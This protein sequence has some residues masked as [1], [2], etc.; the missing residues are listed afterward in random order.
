MAKSLWFANRFR[1]S[2]GLGI[3]YAVSPKYWILEPLH[4]L[5]DFSLINV[6]EDWC[7]WHIL[8]EIPVL[9]LTLPRAVEDYWVWRLKTSKE[10]K[11]MA[12]MGRKGMSIN[13][14]YFSALSQISHRHRHHGWIIGVACSTSIWYGIK[15][16]WQDAQSI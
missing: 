1:E 2:S 7:F 14:V 11:R 3:Q 16:L 5:F 6:S 4:T 13:F 8:W 15:S 9:G 12:Q 10:R